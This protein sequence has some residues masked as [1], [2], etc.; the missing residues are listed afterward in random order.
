MEKIRQL[1]EW[2]GVKLGFM[3]HRS[4]REVSER[5]AGYLRGKLGL[6]LHGPREASYYYTNSR[7]TRVR[8]LR[9]AIADVYKDA[10]IRVDVKE[11]KIFVY[12]V[13]PR[14]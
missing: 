10:G 8:A 9:L 12:E 7:E 11:G 1:W 6:Y 3:D 5:A 2:V 14:Y 4:V 13:E